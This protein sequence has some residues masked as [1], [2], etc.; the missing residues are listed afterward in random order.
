MNKKVVRANVRMQWK[1]ANDWEL[2][3]MTHAIVSGHMRYIEWILVAE[4]WKKGDRVP[5]P[6]A[7]VQYW[8]VTARKWITIYTTEN[9]NLAFLYADRWRRAGT[10]KER[11]G[12]K[13]MRRGAFEGWS[14]TEYI[15][16]T[17]E[18]WYHEAPYIMGVK[19][20]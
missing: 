2:S 1:T 5:A 20:M 9:C 8:D 4:T 6:K 13:D 11:P 7:D 15:G 19:E 12:E 3:Y 10:T 14:R 17:L 16:A 18:N